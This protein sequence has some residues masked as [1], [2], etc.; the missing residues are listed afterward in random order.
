MIN[1]SIQNFRSFEDV[2]L[3]LDNVTII[4][5]KNDSGKSNLFRALYYFFNVKQTLKES[6]RPIFM[7]DNNKKTCVSFNLNITESN[8]IKKILNNNNLKLKYISKENDNYWC[9]TEDQK[10]NL[11]NLKN[12]VDKVAEDVIPEIYYIDIAKLYKSFDLFNVWDDIQSEILKI[13]IDQQNINSNYEYLINEYIL[14]YWN[15]DKQSEIFLV[16]ETEG[17]FVCHARD[18]NRIRV[19]LCDRGTGFQTF[20]Y[21]L[22]SIIKV[23]KSKNNKRNII[24][25]EEPERMMHPQ[26]QRDFVKLVNDITKEYKDIYFIITTHSPVI[27][28]E[29]SNNKILLFEKSERGRTLINH[30]PY[31]ENWKKL[32]YALGMLPSDSLIIGKVTVLVEGICEKLFIPRLLEKFTDI[33]ISDINFIDC[34]GASNIPYILD[35]VKDLPTK[36]VV[37]LDGDNQGDQAYKKL[38][39][40]SIIPLENIISL[41]NKD[42]RKKDIAFEDVFD[43]NLL[44]EGLRKIYNG[45]SITIEDM[46]KFKS[47]KEHYSKMCWGRFAKKYLR[48]KGIIQEDDDLKKVELCEFLVSNVKEFPEKLSPLL[49]RLKILLND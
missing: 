27:V 19:N 28:N 31:N 8:K 22:M 21:Y 49:E 10:I 1:L 6:D 16:N 13:L 12:K 18:K 24:M 47:Q 39:D 5:G 30:K 36:I 48:E 26:A 15:S 2:T 20:L 14:K 37:L 23:V 34:N 43:V 32:R 42:S 25:I 3:A 35:Y 38:R 17:K 45:N 44:V 9:Y 11:N 46:D 29:G 33:K 4:V 7:S 41:C 40:N